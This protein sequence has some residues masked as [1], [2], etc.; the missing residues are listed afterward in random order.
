MLLQQGAE[1]STFL[2][3][4]QLPEI[5]SGRRRCRARCAPGG[6]VVASP[7]RTFLAEIGADAIFHLGLE[8][9]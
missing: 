4:L 5:W 7:D 8:R 9:G 1:P 2:R 3:A 6:L